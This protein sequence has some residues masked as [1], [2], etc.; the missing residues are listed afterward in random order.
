MAV[1]SF[2]AGLPSFWI[3]AK[4][5]ETLP[6][7]VQLTSGLLLSSC[8]NLVL[9]EA[10]KNL[11]PEKLTSSSFGAQLLLGFIVLYSIEVFSSSFSNYIQNRL[12][13]NNNSQYLNSDDDLS[14]T[15]EVH[16]NLNLSSLK[17]YLLSVFSNSITLGLV[18]H[19]LTDGIILTTSLLSESSND[20]T[21][22]SSNSFLIILALFLHKLPTSFSLTSILLDEKLSHSL[23]LFHLLIFSVSAPIGAW[24]TY[25]LTNIF[26]ISKSDDSNSFILLFSTG[27]FL[28]V[29]FH[30]FISC[31]KH[32]SDNNNNKLDSIDSSVNWNYLTTIIGMI[33]P[34]LVG[35]L[36]D[37]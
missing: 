9:P 35:F 36:H 29:S 33:I 17:Y 26:D 2:L 24:L 11:S 10:I 15:N 12:F 14:L 34:L 31:H 23:V 5:H 13:E 21:N 22:K 19:C 30:T 3:L 16:A 32:D 18:L 6:L 4:S 27:A 20:E 1:V 28:Y 8:I 25:F 7:M 37:D